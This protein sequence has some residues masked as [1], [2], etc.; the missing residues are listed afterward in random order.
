MKSAN[1][2][3]LKGKLSKFLDFVRKGEHVIVMDRRRPIA[4]ITPYE[5][6]ETPR[7]QLIEPTSNPRLLFKKTYPPVKG[8]VANSLK[9][10]LQEREDRR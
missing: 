10:L 9:A 4:R 3:E 1:I 5:K 6:L 7:L 8:K 2:A